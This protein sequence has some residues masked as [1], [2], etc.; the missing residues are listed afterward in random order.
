M[1]FDPSSRPSITNPLLT[2][3][4]KTMNATTYRYLP[5]IVLWL[6]LCLPTDAQAQLDRVFEG[7][8]NEILGDK[9]A[10]TRVPARD[11]D[12][13]I[14]GNH[15]DHFLDAAGSANT[16][17]VSNLNNLI[18]SNVSSFP[19]SATSAGLSFDFSS[20]QPVAVRE[21]LGPIFAE[22]G[23]TIGKGR[24]LMGTN[25]SYLDL[26]KYRGM[27]TE[28]IR[29]TFTHQNVSPQDDGVLGNP[30][31]ENDVIDVFLGLDVN[32]NI[33]AFYATV[34]LTDQLD[35]SFALPV[36]NISVSGAARAVINSFSL[37]RNGAADHHFGELGTE[38]NEPQLEHVESYSENE[39]GIGDLAVRLKYAFFDDSAID[40]AVLLDARLPTGDEANFMGT[41][42]ANVRLSGIASKTFGDFTP[43]LN[44]GYEYRGAEYDS[45]ELEF[46]VGFDQQLVKG[47][48][49]AVDIL[50]EFDLNKEDA[51]DFDYSPE[52]IRIRSTLENGSFTRTIDQNNIPW[53]INDDGILNAA[54]GF[55]AAPADNINFLA[56]ILVPL[57]DDGLRSDVVYTVGF[58]FTF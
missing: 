34:G 24:V 43:H 56:N 17:I 57:N 51:L 46:A 4:R 52:P 2:T 47:L 22:L 9:G 12:G 11:S 41:G 30:G 10:L 29:F 23:K 3:T 13:N 31:T 39:F 19:L 15:G 40:A 25:Y 16:V 38:G 28:D 49:F 35:I 7:V 6:C 14:V 44:L 8:F 54:M 32:A 18:A 45:D 53:R 5:G 26:D 20:G 1:R 50:G 36:I 33:F 48:T 58:A 27:R 37:A 21:S 55:R 42:K